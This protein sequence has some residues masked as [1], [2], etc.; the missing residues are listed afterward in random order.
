MKHVKVIT[1][2]YFLMEKKSDC[3]VLG[4]EYNDQTGYCKKTLCYNPLP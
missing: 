4:G 1:D 2:G 3:E